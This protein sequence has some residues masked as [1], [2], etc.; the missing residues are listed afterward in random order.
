MKKY[1]ALAV[2]G[3][4][5]AATPA[6]AQQNE[7]PGGF[8]I[9]ALGGYE[10]VDVESADG[11]A[12]A[13][14]DSVVYGINAGYDLSLGGAF[15]GAVVNLPSILGRDLGGAL[16][17]GSGRHDVEQQ[18][19]MQQDRPDRPCRHVAQNSSDHGSCLRG[20]W[21]GTAWCARSGGW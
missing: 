16:A 14:A 13:T 1:I 2:I 4:G 10:G 5:F 18:V 6:M 19:F 8:Y 15:I 17:R 21:T 11:S 9:G 7:A 12:T 20:S 3:A